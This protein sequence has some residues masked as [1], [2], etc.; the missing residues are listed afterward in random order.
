MMCGCAKCNKAT[1]V[2]LLVIGIVFLLVDVGVWDFWGLQWWTI[3]FLLMGVTGL[4]MSGCPDCRAL[5]DV[6]KKERKKK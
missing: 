5:Y 4:A 6:P 2:L 3:G 1:A